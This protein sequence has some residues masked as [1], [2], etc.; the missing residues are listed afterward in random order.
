MRWRGA[1]CLRSCRP[2]AGSRFAFNCR[3]CCAHGLTVVVSPLISLMKDQVDA[4]QASG[5]AATFLN[6][7]L[8]GD[9][10]ADAAAR[11]LHNGEFRLLY[12]APERLML[13][14]FHREAAKAGTSRR[15]RSTKRIASANGA[16]ISGRNTASWPSCGSIFPTCR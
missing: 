12:V 16:T 14:V 6:S 11:T 2:A 10:S 4:L 5:I 8:D 3:P 1:M 13:R 15:S 7:T 9:A